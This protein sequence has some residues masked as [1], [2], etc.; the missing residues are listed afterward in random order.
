MESAGTSKSCDTFV[1]AQIRG[2]F[3]AEVESEAKSNPCDGPGGVSIDDVLNGQSTKKE[4]LRLAKVLC[5]SG[6]DWEK[7]RTL[8]ETLIDLAVKE[9]K[10]LKL[11]LKFEDLEFKEATHLG[12]EHLALS[13]GRSGRAYPSL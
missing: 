5:E 9:N 10:E 2:L 6:D 8:L 12:G 13:F 3:Q 1:V 11:A 7:R 4:M